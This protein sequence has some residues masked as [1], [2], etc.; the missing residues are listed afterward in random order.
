[1]TA[2]APAPPVAKL[3]ATMRTHHGDTVVDEY[4]WLADQTDPDTIAYAE[5]ENAY[6]QA[7]TVDLAELRDEIFDEI[8]SRTKESDLSVPVRKNGYWY[9]RRT[10]AGQQYEVHCRLPVRGDDQTPPVADGEA[11][12]PGELVLLDG[13]TEAGDADYFALGALDVSPDGTCL[14]Y[15]VDLTGEEQFTLRVKDLRTGTVLPDEVPGVWYG[16]AWSTDASTL[17]Y[18]KVDD[19]WRPYQIWRHAVGTDPG[20]DVLVLE[21]ADPRFA[22]GLELSRSGKVIMVEARSTTT[23]EVH[24]IPADEPT[25]P[26]RVVAPRREGVDYTVDHD[27][28]HDRLLVLHNDGA[29]DFALAWTPAGQ[30]GPWHDL[31]PPTAGTRLLAVTAFAGTIALALRSGGQ[32][33]V[34]LIPTRSGSGTPYDISFPEPV[35]T[36][37][38][39][40]NLEYDTATVRLRYVSLVTPESIYDYHLGSHELVLRKQVEVL[41]YQPDRYAQFRESAVADDGTKIPMS[42][43]CRTDTPRDGSAPAVLYGYGSYE[44][45]VDPRFSVPRLSLLDRGFVYIT[46]HVRGGGELGRRWYTDGSR[47]AK[48]TTFTDFVACAHALAATGWTAPDRLV[49]RGASA[50]GLLVAALANLAPDAVAGI[51]AQMPFVDP[52]TTMLDPTL[53]LTVTE[54][55]EWGNPVDSP[56]A[57]ACLKSYSPYENVVPVKYPAVL[58]VASLNDTRVLVREPLKWIARLRA[59]AP[60]GDY[61]LRTDM[62]AGHTGRS[63]R[64]DAWRE[65]AFVLAWII[66]LIGTR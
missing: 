66:R 6:T 22:L 62:S 41:G 30:P 34:R 63:G 5:A 42:I 15:S 65:E 55:E 28:E 61:L 1:M 17:F 51:V 18:V 3:V 16:C 12:L 40:Q 33:A 32:T 14:A 9:Y 43:V 7:R 19:A 21:E 46:A 58:A 39:D 38:L 4:A 23:T 50:G 64:Y 53:P 48:P 49:A 56:E 31:V 45:C 35:Y 20:Q 27:P 29:E 2:H 13:N 44:A 57:Y 26:P 10:T 47:L 52:L 11:P 54:W 59:V 60:D 37:G 25:A 36:V 24:L 8:R